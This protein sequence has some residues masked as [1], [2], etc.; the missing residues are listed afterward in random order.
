MVSAFFLCFVSCIFYVVHVEYIR[1][2]SPVTIIFV[3][4]CTNHFL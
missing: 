4:F 1:F 3:S 2:D